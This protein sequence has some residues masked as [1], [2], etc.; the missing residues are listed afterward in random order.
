M[1]Y[2]LS[3]DEKAYKLLS[4]YLTEEQRKQLAQSYDRAFFDIIVPW[5]K[6]LPYWRR[7]FRIYVKNGHNVHAITKRGKGRHLFCLMKNEALMPDFDLALAI[8]FYLRT[9]TRRTLIKGFGW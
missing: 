8:M 5:Y 1:T 7:R 9:R 2:P 6:V 3:A 4:S